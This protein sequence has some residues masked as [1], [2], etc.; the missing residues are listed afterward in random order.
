MKRTVTANIS[1]IVLH[2][3]EDAYATL[4]AYLER[5]REHLAGEE[6]L[7]EIMEDVEARIVELFRENLG[8]TKEVVTEADVERTI[9]ILGRPEAFGDADSPGADEEEE[10]KSEGEADHGPEKR[11][12]RDP[13][14]KVLGGVCSGISAY[15]GWDPLWLRLAFVVAVL[16]AGVG[17]I[18]YLVLWVIVPKARTRTEKLHMRG[19]AVNLDN[20]KKKV[21][22]ESEELKDR[23]GKFKKDMK[24][25]EVK[26]KG[27]ELGSKLKEVFQ[28]IFYWIGKGF[29]KFGAALLLLLGVVFALVLFQAYGGGG[30]HFIFLH[31]AEKDYTFNETLN[32]FIKAPFHQLLFKIGFALFIA[33]PTFVFFYSGIK[34]LFEM[35]GRLRGI[36]P[37]LLILWLVGLLICLYTGAYWYGAHLTE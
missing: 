14:D 15:L 6:G 17:P 34:S 4:E 10:A 8:S 24:S 25:D 11:I 1:G 31:T 21:K 32:L 12:Y 19:E 16:A 9:E 35:N 28:G 33:I 27:K 2:I 20:L 36:G 7:E 37:L 18:I 26:G 29:E 3:E 23:F 30:D 5:I 13:D 22:E